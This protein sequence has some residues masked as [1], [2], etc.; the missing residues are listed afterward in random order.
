MSKRIIDP[1]NLDE[2]LNEPP[3]GVCDT[4]GRKTWSAETCCGM[5]Q[6]DGTRCP[7]KFIPFGG[8]QE[9]ARP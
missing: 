9:S 7:G 4:C 5:P 3:K 1:R 2:W 8:T 6:P